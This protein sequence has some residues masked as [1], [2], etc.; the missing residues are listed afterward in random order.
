[1]L[2]LYPGLFNDPKIEHLASKHPKSWSVDEVRLFFEC[3]ETEEHVATLV[4]QVTLTTELLAPSPP[5]AKSV[6]ASS[7]LLY[8]YTLCV[9]YKVQYFVCGKFP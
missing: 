5:H 9:L 3:T 8:K 4:E 1:M 6:L 2:L 7:N